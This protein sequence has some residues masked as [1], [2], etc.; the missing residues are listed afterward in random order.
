M[1]I[2]YV[3]IVKMIKD[4]RE[5]YEYI[6]NAFDCDNINY[7]IFFIYCKHLFNMNLDYLKIRII[8]TLIKKMISIEII[9]NK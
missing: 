7:S 8:S 1:I 4:E 2:E 9:Y 6:Y 3:N 5:E